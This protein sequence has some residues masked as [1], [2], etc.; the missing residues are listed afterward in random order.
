MTRADLIVRLVLSAN[1]RDQPL[2]RKTAEALIA[3]ERAQQHHVLASRLRLRTNAKGISRS[4]RLLEALTNQ[5][6]LEVI[7]ERTLDDLELSPVA[8]QAAREGVEEQH[9][10]EF[11]PSY[12]LDPGHWTLFAGP[13]GNGKTSLAKART[14]ELIALLCAVRYEAMAASYL[15]ETST[16]QQR[17]SKETGCR[18]QVVVANKN[19]ILLLLFLK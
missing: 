9:R 1:H 10:A 4:F 11:L 13:P 6:A 8:G 15:G 12:S 19:Y 18:A 3:E 2:L 17:L 7:P 14:H 5:Q 16:R